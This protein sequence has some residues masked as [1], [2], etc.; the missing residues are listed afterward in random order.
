M[1]RGDRHRVRVPSLTENVNP[2]REAGVDWLQADLSAIGKRL[3][4]NPTRS[5]LV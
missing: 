2:S 5:L 1:R 3:P 4:I